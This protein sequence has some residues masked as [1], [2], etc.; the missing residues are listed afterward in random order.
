MVSF[1][2]LLA[3]SI[4]DKL[5]VLKFFSKKSPWGVLEEG[6]LSLILSFFASKGVEALSGYFK[7]IIP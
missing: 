5:I 3:R 6:D 7:G 1:Y 2:W 4:S